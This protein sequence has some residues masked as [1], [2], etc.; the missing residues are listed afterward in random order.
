MQ[1]LPIKLIVRQHGLP[2]SP[3]S[4]SSSTYNTNFISQLLLVI[5]PL[6]H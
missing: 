5:S 2:H 3:K 6:A 1:L 4:R